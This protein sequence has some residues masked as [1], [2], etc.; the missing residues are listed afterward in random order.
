MKKLC[1]IRSRT[2]H[3]RGKMSL[4]EI[5]VYDDHLF[6]KLYG[7][8][9]SC[10]AITIQEGENIICSCREIM[11]VPSICEHVAFVLDKVFKIEEIPIKTYVVTHNDYEHTLDPYDDKDVNL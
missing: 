3:E 2:T 8:S 1:I 9:G 5:D 10:Y 6:L 4:H 11:F 7:L